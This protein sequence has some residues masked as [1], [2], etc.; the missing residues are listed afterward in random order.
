MAPAQL[1]KCPEN[2]EGLSGH[3]NLK[4]LSSPELHPSVSPL[5]FERGREP[6]TLKKK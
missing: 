5:S 6:L 4:P 3:L 1:N 2:R